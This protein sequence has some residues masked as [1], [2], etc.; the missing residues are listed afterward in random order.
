MLVGV[1]VQYILKSTFLKQ[2]LIGNPIVQTTGQI[3][4]AAVYFFLS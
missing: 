2:C 4:A 3:K 1:C